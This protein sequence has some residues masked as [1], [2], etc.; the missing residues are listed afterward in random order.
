MLLGLLTHLDLVQQLVCRGKRRSEL[1]PPSLVSRRQACCSNPVHLSS[2]ARPDLLCHPDQ[3]PLQHLTVQVQPRHCT[4]ISG[5]LLCEV[6]MGCMN[7]AL[8]AT[9]IRA[10]ATLQPAHLCASSQARQY[11]CRSV[12]P[13]ARL[14]ASSRVW[15]CSPDQRQT[16]LLPKPITAPGAWGCMRSR[17]GPSTRLRKACSAQ[18]CSTMSG[19][20]DC[21]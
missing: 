8:A 2:Y 10:A 12:R 13:S 9:C 3:A 14:R 21:L 20:R 17:M 18:Q 19:R 4:D 6:C 11:S 5:G 16:E 15:Q 1:G 7:M